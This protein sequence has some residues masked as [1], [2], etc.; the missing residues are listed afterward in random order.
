MGSAPRLNQFNTIY[1]KIF[2][3]YSMPINGG[4]TQNKYH[5][6]GSCKILA[7]SRERTVSKRGFWDVAILSEPADSG[8]FGSRL[9]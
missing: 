3:G 6:Y 4:S 9:G 2:V 7:G 8:N 1:K 5:L